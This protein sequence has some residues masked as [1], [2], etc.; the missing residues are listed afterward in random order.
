MYT[1][2]EV[3]VKR[4]VKSR[5]TELGQVLRKARG[6]DSLRAMAEKIKIEHSTLSDLERGL[7][8]PD[9][10]TLV[11]IHAALGLPLEEV[12]R[13]AARDHGLQLPVE[14]TPYRDLAAR[15]AARSIVFPDLGKILGRLSDVDPDAYRSFS[16]ML[17]LWE[18]QD[19]E[20]P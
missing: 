2:D 19:D 14:P 6:D 5:Q 15:L 3:H 18:R 7:R 9:F 1:V 16:L 12:V 20:Q 10:E 4:Q 17:D 13:M 8:R 11:N